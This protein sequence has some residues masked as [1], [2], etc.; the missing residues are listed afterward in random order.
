MSSNSNISL[1]EKVKEKN[2]NKVVYKDNL[3]NSGVTIALSK[4]KYLGGY[5]DILDEKT[6][7]IVVKTVGVFFKDKFNYSYL[8][9]PVEK[10][11][12]AEFK[13]GEQTAKSPVLSRILAFSG[14]EFANSKKLRK[15]LV[16]L[17]ITYKEEQVEG[18]ILFEC[19]NASKIA[20]AITKI[21]KENAKAKKVEVDQTLIE[22]MKEISI[23]RAMNV[24]TEEEFLEKKKD[25]LSRM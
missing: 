10:I 12:K 5:P 17:T 1:L 7:D 8:F 6:G 19:K 11:V 14:F 22:L 24:L 15:S 4:A 18:S 13:T 23:L 2:E 16:F 21:I 20:S 9:V 3:Q 25:L